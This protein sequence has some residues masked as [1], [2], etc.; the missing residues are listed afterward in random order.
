[1]LILA[2]LAGTTGCWR[3]K[4][5]KGADGARVVTLAEPR[6]VDTLVVPLAKD[7]TKIYRLGP[8]DVV[9]IDVRKDPSLSLDYVVTDEGNI[10]LPNGLGPFKVA[11]L[12]AAEVEVKLNEM[13]TE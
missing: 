12:T 1:V 7:P 8:E 4:A 13:L 2:G 3:V 5:I 10:L 9:R 11:N 6:P